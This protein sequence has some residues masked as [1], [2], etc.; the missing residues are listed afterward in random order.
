MEQFRVVVAILSSVV[1]VDIN[2][3]VSFGQRLDRNFD[4]VLD[5]NDSFGYLVEEHS[6]QRKQPRQMPSRQSVPRLLKKQPGY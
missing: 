1:K 4:R 2:E 6:R 3:K 5:R